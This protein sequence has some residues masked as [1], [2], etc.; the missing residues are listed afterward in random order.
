MKKALLTLFCL[1]TLAASAQK[2]AGGDISLVPAYE[3]AGDVW[4][5]GDGKAIN[6]QYSDGMLTYLH[7][8]AGWNAIRV[9]L[10]ADP[11][12][13]DKVATCQDLEYVKK[14]GKRIKDAGMYFLL[15]FFYSDTWTDVSQQW[16]PAGWGF[17]RTTATETIAAK[18]KDYTIEALNA[19]AAAGATPDYVQIGNEVSYGMLWDNASGKNKSNWFVTSSNY[20]EQKTQIERFA[21]LLKAAAEGVRAS[22]CNQAKIILHCERTGNSTH[23]KNFYTWVEQAGFTDYDM[24]GLS[25]YP[26]WHGTMTDLDATLSTLQTAFPSKQIHIVE[27]GYHNNSG[28]EIKAGEHNTSGKWPYS[29]AGQ[30]SFLKDLIATMGKYTNVTGLYYWQPEECGNGADT[31]GKNRVMDGWDNRGFWELTWKSGHHKLISQDAL[32]TVKTFL[33]NNTGIKTVRSIKQ[34]DDAW[35]TLD[36]RR[37]TEKPAA[38]GLYIHD[39]RKVVVR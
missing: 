39:G 8:V 37:L 17:N 34:Q 32:M 7:D 12:Q 2:L 30:A 26:L 9:R 29:P 31:N 13:D 1:T 18:V 33:G 22:N 15:D 21:A 23:C 19:L 36:G 16:I 5:D 27:A 24:I 38:K 10:L 3:A 28:F 6:T 25:Y 4:L 35:Y 11:S 20:N 14:L